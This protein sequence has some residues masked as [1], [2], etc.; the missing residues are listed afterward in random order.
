MRAQNEYLEN[1][2]LSASPKQLHLMV[3]DGAIRNARQAQLLIQENE[4]EAA[5]FALNKSRECVGELLAGLNPDPM[6]ATIEN[7]KALFLFVHRQLMRADLEHDEQNIADAIS[8][9]EQYRE[10]WMTLINQTEHNQTE[11][12][13][14]EQTETNPQ[15]Q[16]PAPHFQTQ[17]E[18]A[19]TKTGPHISLNI[20]SQHTWTT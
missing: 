6:P 9:L 14:T 5:H 19:R 4:F 20:E 7:L 18:K 1:Q 2:V 13:Q 10:T 16:P 15:Q 12:N 11:R 17:G 3:V 8:I